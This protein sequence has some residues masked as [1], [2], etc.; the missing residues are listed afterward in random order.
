MRLF[1]RTLHRTAKTTYKKD[2]TSKIRFKL[3]ANNIVKLQERPHCS[4]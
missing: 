2:Q 4:C 3:M 1:R